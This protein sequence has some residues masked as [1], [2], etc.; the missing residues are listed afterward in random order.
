LD[1]H[2]GDDEGRFSEEEDDVKDVILDVQPTCIKARS[3]EK[4]P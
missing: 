3:F 1:D 4:S 2:S